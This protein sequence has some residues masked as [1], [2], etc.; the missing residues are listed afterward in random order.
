M[1]KFILFLNNFHLI[2]FMLRGFFKRQVAFFPLN[3]YADKYQFHLLKF[4]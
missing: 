3:G 2:K 4:D 1:K